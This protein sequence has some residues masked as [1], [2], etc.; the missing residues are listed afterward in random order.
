M[1]SLRCGSLRLGL[2]TLL[3]VSLSNTA[4]AQEASAGDPASSALSSTPQVSTAA[5]SPQAGVY[6][7][8]SP[9][10]NYLPVY[11]DPEQDTN[12]HLGSTYIPL[13]SPAN[14][15]AMRLYA[16]GYLDTSFL[17]MRPWT[18]RSLL[19]ALNESAAD[20]EDFGSDEAV[21]ILAKLHE[22]LSSEAPGPG[23]RRGSVTGLDTVYTRLMGIKGQTLRDSYHLG[24]TLVNDYGRPYQP[25]FNNVTG[26]STVNEWGRFSLY[27]RGEYQHSPSNAGYSLA[28]AN[29][30][31][32]ND[33]ICPFAPPNAPQDTIPYGNTGAQNP[34][35]LQQAALSFHVFGHEI[36]GGKS[37][38]WTG[39]ALGGSFGWSNNAE[40]I[41]SVRIN[42]VEPLHIP[43]LSALLGPV[44]YDVMVGSLKGHTAPNNP[45]VHNTQFSFRPYRDFEFGLQRTVIWGGK[46]HEPVTLHTFFR[47]FFDIGDSTPA[48]KNSREDPGARFS[49]FN[50]SWRLPFLR[51]D[52]T[53]YTDSE[54]HDD[55]LP[56]SAPRRAAFRPGILLSHLPYAPKLEMRVE[57][58]NTDPDVIPSQNGQFQYYEFIQKQGYTNKGFIF[59]DWAGREGKGGQA[60]LTYHLS[61]NEWVQ[62]EYMHK[63]N[64]KDF[65]PGGT[66]QNQFK[67]DVVKRLRK[68]IELNAWVQYERWK[69]PV[70]KAGGQ[71]DTV[72][73]G[74]VI[75]YPKLKSTADKLR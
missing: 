51:K 32:C 17:G 37:D 22:Y 71:S 56:V 63:K 43:F 8:A 35:R 42:R 16:L 21:D 9:I 15:M 52:V 65:I 28:L 48:E 46:G 10:P 4:R 64:D 47:S 39:P 54:T 55:N 1:Y 5:P 67:I 2:V 30:L 12:D 49:S 41:Y 36:S 31:S 73:A 72:I 53:L 13:D 70:Y 58:F 11:I 66:T 74:E 69:A 68:D 27:A 24:Q 33:S 59:G 25:G 45:W 6:K 14:E 40:D 29:T 38:A 50:F 23:Y 26:F 60:W 62:A 75:F 61:G 19:H 44:R 20:I 7:N 18:R 3:C 57:G 34:F